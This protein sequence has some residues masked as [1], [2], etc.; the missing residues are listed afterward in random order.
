MPDNTA[1]PFDAAVASVLHTDATNTAV[2]IRNNVQF[3]VG[4]NPD[5]AAQYQH[6]AKYVGVPVET[7]QAQPDAIKQQ[8]ALKSMDAD[9]M[10]S[11]YPA[12]S[13][14]MVDPNNVAKS[15][16]DIAPL[17]A[18]EQAARAVPTSPAP[19]V[20]GP[21]MV[22]T[23]PAAPTVRDR[24][25]DWWASMVGG[26]NAQQ[27]RFQQQAAEA[28]AIMAARASNPELRPKAGATQAQIDD[29]NNQAWEQSRQAVGG[30]SQIPQVAA[31]RFLGAASLGI[32]QPNV[33]VKP[34]TWQSSTAGAVA[35]L[36][37]FVVGPA[38]L[39]GAAIG[40]VPGAGALGAAAGEAWAT[41]LAKQVV[42]QAA[43][44]GLASGLQEAGG[45]VL[46]SHTVGEGAAKLGHATASGAAVGGVFGAAG[47]LLPDNTIAQWLGRAVG[48]SA[49]QDA[50]SGANPFDDR[51]LEDKLFGYGMNVLFTAHGAGRTTGNWFTDHPDVRKGFEDANK[52]Q[53]AVD[54]G[55]AL[56]ALGELAGASKTRERDP[57]AFKQFVRSVTEDDQLHE[58]Y[59]DANKFAE[60]LNQ[61]G[62]DIKQ[63]AERMPEVAAQFEQAVHLNGDIRIP[64]EDYATHI[65]GGKMDAA[66]LPHLK[67]EAEGMTYAQGQ[68]HLENMQAEMGP[69][70]EKLVA[71]KGEH[72]AAQVDGQVVHDK[73]LDQ[74]NA[75]GRFRPE[76]NKAYAA[77]TRD[78][79]V[80]Q[81]ERAGMT[82]SELFEK[83]PL[84]I[85]SEAIGSG[86][87]L[88]Q[89]P[90]DGPFGPIARQF[91][92]DAAGAIAH[93]KE[94]QSGE[95]VSALSHPDVGDIDLVWGKEGTGASDG[96]GLAKLVKY[97][98]EVLDDLQGILSGMSVK[99]RSA[100][101]V[102]LESA[103]HRAGVRLT[104]DGEAKNWLMTAFEKKGGD[105]ADTRTDTDGVTSGGDTARPADISHTSIDQDLNNFYQGNRGG[106]N[107]ETNTISLLKNADLSTYLHESGHFFLE[108]MHDMAS[109]ADA[110]EG[111]RKDFDTL[112]QSFGEAGATP[113]ERAASWSA[114]TL[115][116]K[117]AGHE[118]FAEGFEKYL[119]EGKAPSLELQGLFSR[120]RSWLVSVYKSLSNMTVELTPEVRQ[121]M[122][123]LLASDEAIRQAEQARSY[124]PLTEAPEGTSAEQF[125]A[126]QALG[127]EATEQAV[128][129]MSARSMRDMKWASNAKGKAMK[130]LQTQADAQRKAIR[131]EVAKELEADPVREAEA[132]LKRK[133]GTDPA[134]AA[135]QKAW[136]AERDAQRVALAETVK[137]EYL[138]TPEGAAVKGIKKGQFLA[139]NKRAIENE[140]ERRTIAWEQETPRPVKPKVD[141]DIVAEMFGFTDGKE[142]K[143]AID[144]AGKLKDQIDGMTDQRMLE[145]HGELID[146]PSIERAAEAAIHNEARARFMATG[147]KMLSKSPIPARQLAEAAKQAAEAAI[148]A[149]RVRDLRPAQHM[150]EEARANREVIKLA[151]KDPAGAVQAQRAALLN[152]RLFKAATDAVAEVQKGVDY[153]KKFDK[154]SIRGKIALDI[155]DQIDDLLSR[156]DLRQKVPDGLT[157]KQFNLKEWIES[158]LELGYAPP[159]SV[160]MLDPGVRM[161]FKDMTVEQ[162][163]G[164]IDSVKAM[165][166]IGKKRQEL[167]IGGERVDLDDYVAS[168]IVPKLEE[169]GERFTADD[170]LD[171]ADERSD[172]VFAQ[173]LD[174]L[175][176]WRRA[177]AA[178][179]KPTEFKRNQY[180]MHE[181]LG[182]MGESIFEPV[183]NANYHKVDMLKGLSEDFK[184]LAQD[185][186]KEWQDSLRN[187]VANKELVDPDKSTPGNPK[188]LRITRAK[189]IGIAIHVGNESNFNKLSAGW[190]WK[191]GAV[192]SFLHNHMTEKDWAATQGIWDLYE[193]HWPDMEAMN[194]RL[195]NTSPEKIEPRA[196]PTKFGEQRG[197][198]AAI[199]YDSLRSRRGEKEAQIRAVDPSDGLFG[200][201]YFK[202]DT[203]TNGSMNGRV[204]GYTDRV[205]LDFHH[206]ATRLHETIHDL[207]YREVAIDVNKILEH[208]EF[209]AAFRTAY[210]PEAYRSLQ[211]WL[212]K[213]VNS[214]N[215][216]QQVG[217]LGK[218][219]QYTRTGMVMTAIALR[220]STVAKHGGSAGIKTMGYFVG[221]GEK[222]LA[223]RSASMGT[224]Y[225]AQIT[226]A[227]EKFGEIR[228]RL[229]QQ[230][231]DFRVTSTALFEKEHLQSQAERFGHAAV[232]WSDM[233]TAVPTA[234]AAYDRAITEG[235]P[236]NQGGT[237]K[238]MTEAQ[239]VN[240]ANKIVREAHGSNVET[241]R[242]MVMNTSSEA[243][244]MFTTLY[245]FMNNTLGQAMDGYDKLGTPGINKPVVLARTFMALIVP[246]I[247]AH[248]LTH[249]APDDEEGWAKWA[250]KAVAGE[251]AG[252]VPFVRDAVAMFEGYSHAGVVGA[253]SWMSTIVKAALDVK[254]LA[255]GK[256]VKAPIKDIANAAGMGLHI[257]G[258]GQLGTS[259]QYAADVAAGKEHPADAAEYAKGVATGHGAKKH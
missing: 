5:Q 188:M 147:L 127:A 111:I 153:L 259:A 56:Q 84:K 180:D 160:D 230:D 166:F 195:G 227:Q 65:A 44:L 198:Y 61:S 47:K 196:F 171:R 237:G 251:V 12:L 40:A 242:S 51:P 141:N 60:V 80:T 145:R 213:V 122:D 62:V 42:Q 162:F 181:L 234:W 232:A 15:H 112:L 43:T 109:A 55:G 38:K 151:P 10:V 157:R 13:K 31:E 105:V 209:R 228:A 64:V 8:A 67:A 143:K 113:E 50:I 77:L 25:V 107:P 83:Y 240:Y 134:P 236:V 189:M 186:G 124:L 59:V 216:D 149:K 225:T 4:Q 66:L 174:K 187:M 258:L 169:R 53:A 93:L 193:K 159:V 248:T 170:L 72:D 202:A 226:D 14:Y 165:E 52:A 110:P 45:A 238:P 254:H 136:T 32:M 74:L 41:G 108:T 204:D 142:M 168:K 20:S 249:G 102:N 125:A 17:A 252:M 152:N 36:A 19:A 104:W 207:A 79:Y 46:D 140:A 85:T 129:D 257:P 250:G 30:M 54:A 94:Q 197:G 220:A 117:R 191:P 87:G 57:E 100:N 91:K 247:W 76:V 203:T 214:E 253:E 199:A 99:S 33:Q 21:M 150:A 210:G 71:G 97:H 92:G 78:F 146:G 119:M 222:Y 200:R 155:R 3:A 70:A 89:S 24:L 172:N 137:A 75:N 231:R 185:Q 130:A 103:D 2:Q 218:F 81:A 148:A 23:T 35:S 6:L 177:A 27:Q 175:N 128:N 82:P 11:D 211:E 22:A 239:A 9:K 215:G 69:L 167:T 183:I 178:Q 88:D 144:A 255:E 179:L 235:V 229:L 26:P 115:E 163:R 116:E 208:P 121:V 58:V 221:G 212:G 161:H 18:V 98:P 164:L 29:L 173:A 138:A 223:S 49:A 90:T 241:A 34:H 1:N 224:D 95:A 190:G 133:D 244:K 156:F 101:R 126:Y 37:G 194:R 182:P 158:Q 246:A 139:K 28:N 63:L 131:E 205:E 118:Q 68:A 192:W 123:R 245:G 48:V 256:E 7:V 120:F 132:Y 184:R 114:K 217:A 106:F 243:L 206:I 176:A 135:E 16:D 86:K 96:Y 233:M 219:L 154:D 39:A 73:V 201:G